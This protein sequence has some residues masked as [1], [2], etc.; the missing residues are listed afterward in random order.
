M[1]HDKVI[2]LGCLSVVRNVPKTL[3]ERLQDCFDVHVFLKNHGV[4]LNYTLDDLK[5]DIEASSP[6]PRA[7]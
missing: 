6:F 7:A 5:H 4:P 2:A 1:T 3:Q